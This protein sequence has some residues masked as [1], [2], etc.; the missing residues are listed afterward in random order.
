M[1]GMTRR[2]SAAGPAFTSMRMPRNSV[3]AAEL[4][5]S[6]N[7]GMPHLRFLAYAALL[8]CRAHAACT[9]ERARVVALGVFMAFFYR[10]LG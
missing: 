6:R 7:G 5:A 4:R 1:T 3:L 8:L 10:E 9:H 2:C